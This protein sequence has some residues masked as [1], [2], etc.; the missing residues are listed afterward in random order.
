MSS[1]DIPSDLAEALISATV[2]LEPVVADQNF[3]DRAVPRTHQPS[4]GLEAYSVGVIDAAGSGQ[5]TGD[6]G[7]LFLGRARQPAMHPLLQ[8]V[9]DA[10]RQERGA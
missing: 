2:E 7:E 8:S 9:G 4:S 3:V 6:V 1:G 5:P 10:P